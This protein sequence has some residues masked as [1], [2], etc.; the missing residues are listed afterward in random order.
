VRR[1]LDQRCDV[2][3]FDVRDTRLTRGPGIPGRNEHFREPRGARELP[4]E[5]MLATAAADDEDVQW[6]EASVFT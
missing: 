3:Q 6:R 1:E 5:R 2:G 4:R